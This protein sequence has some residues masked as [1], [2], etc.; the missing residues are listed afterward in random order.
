MIDWISLNRT[1]IAH[2]VLI[3]T[4]FLLLQITAAV[5]VYMERKVAAL[6]QQRYGPWLVGP[7]GLTSQE[8]GRAHV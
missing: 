1:L 7:R 2:L 4:V 6:I 3:A 5:L 8:I